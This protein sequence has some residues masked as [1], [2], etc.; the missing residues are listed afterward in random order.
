MSAGTPWHP[1]KIFKEK[2]DQGL[3]A[4]EPAE[5]R[6]TLATLYLHLQNKSDYFEQA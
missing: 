3:P 1:S 4:L 2:S 5:N 6:K